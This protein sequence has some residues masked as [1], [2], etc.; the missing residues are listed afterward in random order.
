MQGIQVSQVLTERE[1]WQSL[2]RS[3]R[4][5]SSSPTSVQL[6]HSYRPKTFQSSTAAQIPG[7]YPITAQTKGKIQ[8][9]FNHGDTKEPRLLAFEPLVH[10]VGARS[11]Y[12]GFLH[13]WER[14]A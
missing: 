5:W 7:Q 6:D 9:H 11:V 1:A 12:I 13:E 8:T 2:R 10:V 4:V 14:Y 3:P